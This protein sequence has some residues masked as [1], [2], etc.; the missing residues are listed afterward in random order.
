[1]H[2]HHFIENII[3]QIPNHEN[4]EIVEIEVGDLAGIEPEHLK[5]HLEE[6]TGWQVFCKVV[7]SKVECSCKY[8]GEA[9]VLQRLH[10][11]VIY[12]CPNCNNEPEVLEGKDIKIGKITYK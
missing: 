12:D 10:N 4:V 2:E 1:M 3:K 5:E 7:K 8:K 11:M 9:R 6:H